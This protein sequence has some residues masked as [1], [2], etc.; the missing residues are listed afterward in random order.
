MV[1]LVPTPL[2]GLVLSVTKREVHVRWA[3]FCGE[4]LKLRVDCIVFLVFLTMRGSS[5]YL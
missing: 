3:F 5:Y 1:L 4:W 2:A